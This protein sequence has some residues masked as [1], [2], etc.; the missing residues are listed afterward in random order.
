MK[1][2]AQ[3][4]EVIFQ[5]PRRSHSTETGPADP[6]VAIEEKFNRHA[7]LALREM[8]HACLR[9]FKREASFAYALCSSDSSGVLKV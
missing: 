3:V 6:R 1:A 5:D 7:F 4:L 8:L 2:Q 9:E